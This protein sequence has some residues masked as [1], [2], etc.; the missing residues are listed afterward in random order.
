MFLTQRESKTPEDAVELQANL[1]PEGP[2]QLAGLSP[3]LPLPATPSPA[4]K[5]RTCWKGPEALGQ[6]PW[7]DLK[8][9]VL[10]GSQLLFYW[11][12]RSTTAAAL[13]P[14]PHP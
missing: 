2:P 12:N 4:Q 11:G 8:Q 13:V 6:H 3:S 14:S 9:R 7:L 10:D 1:F 5:G